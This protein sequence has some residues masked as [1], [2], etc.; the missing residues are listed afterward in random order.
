MLDYNFTG[1]FSI[2]P[3]VW[4]TEYPT[5]TLPVEDKAIFDNEVLVVHWQVQDNLEE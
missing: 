4:Y 2:D 5:L 1:S 3:N